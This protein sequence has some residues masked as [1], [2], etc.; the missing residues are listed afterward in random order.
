MKQLCTQVRKNS[1]DVLVRASIQ[2]SKLVLIEICDDGMN[3]V[4]FK[5]TFLCKYYQIITFILHGRGS[6]IVPRVCCTPNTE[7]FCFLEGAPGA[8]FGI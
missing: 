5:W 6:E 1:H 8:F 4:M 2:M 3:T 7:Q